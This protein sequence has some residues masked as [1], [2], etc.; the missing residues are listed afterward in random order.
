MLLL[1]YDNC[2]RPKLI[3]HYATV[4]VLVPA[5]V[6]EM[7]PN[8]VQLH[9]DELLSAGDFRKVTVG[10]PGAQGAVTGTQGVGVKTPLAAAVAEAVVGLVSDEHIPN[11]GIFVT[12]I[13]SRILAATI[14]SAETPGIVTSKVAGEAPKLHDIL[15]VAVTNCAIMVIPSVYH[16]TISLAYQKLV[17][18][19][20]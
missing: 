4:T 13:A 5:A 10:D 2:L 16:L 12:G 19:A 8:H 6:I 1:N 18:D 3:S 14:L 17:V 20:I 9:L 11:V 15:A 7:T